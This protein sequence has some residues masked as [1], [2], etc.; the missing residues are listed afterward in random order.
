MS[1]PKN[2]YYG[3]VKKLLMMYDDLPH[4]SMQ[5]S[6]FRDAV[7]RTVKQ[8]RELPNGDERIEAVVEVLMKK[9]KTYEGYAMQIHVCEQVVKRWV[10]SFI[11]Q[12]GK[13]AGY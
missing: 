4:D 9:R 6:I 11:N 12:V 10:S 2:Y 3:Y 7:N 5:M 8:V 1:R 13:N